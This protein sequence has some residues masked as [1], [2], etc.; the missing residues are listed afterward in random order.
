MAESEVAAPSGAEY[1]APEELSVP[2]FSVVGFSLLEVFSA[3]DALSV[4]D[5]VESDELSGL[6]GASVLDASGFDGVSVGDS[7][8]V[9]VSDSVGDSVSVADGAAALVVSL[10]SLFGSQ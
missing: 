1:P 8:S 9:G 3:A 10:A 5:G 6:E 2:D 7:V 4:V